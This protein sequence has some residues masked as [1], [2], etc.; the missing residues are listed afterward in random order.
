MS[1]AQLA[2]LSAFVPLILWLLS[3]FRVVGGK[4][5]AIVEVFGKPMHAAKMP[6]LYW[7]PPFPIASV[8]GRVDLRQQQIEKEIEVKTRDD[9]FVHLPVSIQMHVS[10]NP[11]NAVKAYYKFSNAEGQIMSYVLNTVR[12]S[13]SGMTLADL[14]SDR[15]RITNE[16]TRALSERLNAAGYHLDAVLVDQP[17][18][19]K[20]VQAA[21]NRVLAADRLRQAAEKEAEAERIRRV[22]I[23]RAE[24]ESKELQG[25][26]LAKQRTAIANGLKESM[27]T[28]KDAMPGANENMIM[29]LMLATN[30][31]DML[32]TV[33]GNKAATIVVPYGASGQMSELGS[34]LAALRTFGDGVGASLPEKVSDV[35][36]AG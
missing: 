23:A 33:S 35:S 3:G 6:G 19:S 11:I 1:L 7:I 14:F 21:F 16:V 2:F 34:L 31:M 25:M 5:A 24:M 30:Q 17:K 36:H 32:T 15:D 13:A 28:F 10:E 22:G 27:Q 4:T 12:Q 8:V 9:A 18:P 26:G 20:E 29:A